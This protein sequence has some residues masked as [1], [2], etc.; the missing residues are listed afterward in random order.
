MKSSVITALFCASGI[1]AA[2]FTEQRRQRR[3][4]RDRR[5]LRPQNVTTAP[6]KIDSGNA[7]NVEYSSN[8]AGAVLIGNGYTRVSGQIVVPNA[9]LPQGGDAGQQYAASAWVGIDGDTCGSAILQTGIDSLIQ[10]GQQT[11]DAWYEWFPDY[12]YNFD[13]FDI[14][15]GDT[16]E[17]T[18]EAYSS[19]SGVATL[20]NYRTG[21]TVSHS[22]DGQGGNALCQTNAEWIVEDF[23][24]G[25]GLVPFADFG[26]VTFTGVSAI[27][28][29]AEVDS[30][31]STIFDINQDG[32][33]LTD[34]SAGGD[35]VTCRYV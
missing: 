16:I 11:F 12:S 31:G 25:G 21:Q 7:V 8:W 17:M 18:V 32:R 33:V 22:F 2:P 28:N 26:S 5:T 19:A 24:V 15:A 6:A 30:S 23:S 1:F 14:G 29:G 27:S 13:G 35:T 3:A 4:V 10:N 20:T 34:C 9:Q